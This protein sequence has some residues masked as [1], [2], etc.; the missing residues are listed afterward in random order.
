MKKLTVIVLAVFSVAF[1]GYSEA[2]P[3]KRTRMAN[4]IGAYGGGFIGY[5]NYSNDQSGAEQSLEDILASADVPFQ[6]VTSSTE[7]K[8]IGYQVMF[9]YRFLRFFA[10]ELGLAAPAREPG[11]MHV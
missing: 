9:G 8:D 3:K 5:S 11:L 1:A 4:R 7:N 10:A 2:A 6:N